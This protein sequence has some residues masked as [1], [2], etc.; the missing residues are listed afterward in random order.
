M[1]GNKR[2]Y[3]KRNIRKRPNN[4]MRFMDPPVIHTLS[5]GITYST[6]STAY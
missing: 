3:K 1:P 6:I 5:S 4:V 2:R